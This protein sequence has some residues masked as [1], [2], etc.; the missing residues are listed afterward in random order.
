M[1][2]DVEQSR[3]PGA[4][5]P[6][7]RRHPERDGAV[8]AEHQGHVA[9]RQQ[10]VEPVRQL[11]QG[12]SRLAGVLGPRMIPVRAPYLVRQVTV[13]MHLEPGGDELFEQAGCSAT[14]PAPDPAGR[15]LAAL[16]GTPT[17]EILLTRGGYRCAPAGP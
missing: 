11:L 12:G 1:A 17:T 16:L 14:P 2:V 5:T 6:Q 15:R 3:R 9:A 7:S 10:R 13:V 8:P 4:Q